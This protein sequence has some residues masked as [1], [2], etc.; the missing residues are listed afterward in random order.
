M[1]LVAI[2]ENRCFSC[3]GMPV[4]SRLVA[5]CVAF[6]VPLHPIQPLNVTQRGAKR[7]NISGRWHRFGM[8][9]RCCRCIRLINRQLREAIHNPLISGR[10]F[11]ILKR[12][13]FKRLFVNIIPDYR[14]YCLSFIH[15][16]IFTHF[17]NRPNIITF[18]SRT[19]PILI[20]R[21]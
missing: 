14:K 20:R 16:F 17:A 11:L 5:V 6:S 18:A 3:N 12:A 19:Q 15:S 21:V 8:E 10:W 1:P 4:A 9:C 7:K 13:S 2:S